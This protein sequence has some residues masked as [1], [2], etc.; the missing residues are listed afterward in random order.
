MNLPTQSQHQL[1]SCSAWGWRTLWAS[2]QVHSSKERPSTS[3][4]AST[5]WLQI[6]RYHWPPFGSTFL[7]FYE[8]KLGPP[9][10]LYKKRGWILQDKTRSIDI[11]TCG[12]SLKI[13]C[14]WTLLKGLSMFVVYFVSWSPVCKGWRRC[15]ILR[16]PNTQENKLISLII[17]N[18]FSFSMF[19]LDVLKT[20]FGSFT[21]H[22]QL[23]L[24]WDVFQNGWDHYIIFN[25]SNFLYQKG[26]YDIH[27]I[28]TYN[29][30]C[31]FCHYFPRWSCRK[32]KVL[33]RQSQKSLD[34]TAGFILLKLTNDNFWKTN[35]HL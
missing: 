34:W 33:S 29:S 1:P 19:T 6:S 11:S 13:V 25:T 17:I 26:K 21:L 32:V 10:F 22:V 18:V 7:F 3:T 8:L 5:S 27:W 4:S 15:S 20:W 16:T 2:K 35:V 30:I 12:L 9:F 24:G 31:T 14:L 23:G 28:T